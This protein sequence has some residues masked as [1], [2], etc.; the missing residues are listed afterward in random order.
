MY[1]RY[2]SLFAL[3]DPGEA[4]MHMHMHRSTTTEELGVEHELDLTRVN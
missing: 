3:W 1:E 4:P 2:T